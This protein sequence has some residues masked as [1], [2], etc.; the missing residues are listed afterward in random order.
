[1]S[2]KSIID[3]CLYKGAITEKEHAKLL[4]NLHRWIPVSERLPVPGKI[5]LVTVLDN[6]EPRVFIDAY[7][8][9]GFS[10]NGEYVTAWAE[11]PE[12]YEAEREKE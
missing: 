6:G 12:P 3:K 4:R 5:Y 9:Y 8:T 10:G 11:L 1:M 2:V 7:F